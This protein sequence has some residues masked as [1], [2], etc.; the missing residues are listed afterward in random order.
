MR[1]QGIIAPG[2]LVRVVIALILPV[3]APATRA[4]FEEAPIDP[5]SGIMLGPGVF[6]PSANNSISYSDNLLRESS[7]VLVPVDRNR[8]GTIDAY[9]PTEE[10]S[11]MVTDLSAHLSYLL[12][13]RNSWLRASWTPQYRSYSDLAMPSNFA[14]DLKVQ[15]MLI[16]SNGMKVDFNGDYQRGIAESSEVDPAEQRGF[17]TTPFHSRRGEVAWRWQHPSRWGTVV[18]VD[19]TKTRF[20]DTEQNFRGPDP[21]PFF[22]FS[23][24]GYFLDGTWLLNSRAEIYGGYGAHRNKQNRQRFNEYLVEND[25]ESLGADFNG[26]GTLSATQLSDLPERDELK[27]QTLRFGAR[28]IL[29]PRFSGM[30]EIGYTK[31]ESELGLDAG[32]KGMQMHISGTTTLTD[33]SLL[34]IDI[35]RQPLQA[36]A[37]QSQTLTNDA[38][39]LSWSLMPGGLH[40]WTADLGWMSSD[41]QTHIDET[42]TGGGSWGFRINRRSLLRVGI[43]HT[44]RNSD[45]PNSEFDE[46]RVM[47][48]W[49]FGWL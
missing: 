18:T 3:L 41:Y 40:V 36:L 37:D 38:I 45:L 17:S 20:E 35:S 30:A 32:F 16:L 10:V 19:G 12:P 14:H 27:E 8:D 4:Q 2:L 47:L 23:R 13:Y 28:G 22:D 25:E 33:A 11:S 26:D 46:N 31:I 34:T 49:T 43:Q 48:D 39:R 44:A 29:T 21:V 42:W 5:D 15:N 6:T 7:D 24:R 1:S 9:V